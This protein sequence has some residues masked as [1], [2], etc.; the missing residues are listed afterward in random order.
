VR[1]GGLI[2]A[3]CG[4]K[5]IPEKN[6]APLAGRPLI[7]WTLEAA[8][9]STLVTRVV[10]STDSAAI[11]A[12]AQKNGVEVLDRP[13]ELAADDTPMLDV[14]RHA[15]ERLVP[16]DVLVVLQPTSPLRRAEHV[17]EALRILLDEGCD[18]VVSVVEVPH[19]LRPGK[20]MALR[21]RSLVPLGSDPLHRH[22][23]PVYARNGPAV[24]ALRPDRLRGDLYS[25][26]VCAYVMSQLDSVDVDGPDELRLAEL[27]LVSW[28]AR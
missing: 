16:L 17:D 4:S 18:V 28:G 24:L 5:G 3:R 22:T 7:A 23:E 1:I 25:G 10:V 21:E 20:L 13:A 12:E 8:R 26:H 19:N 27:L 11:A 15:F 9:E 6:L 2:P 14:I